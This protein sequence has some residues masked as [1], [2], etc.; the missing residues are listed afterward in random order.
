M[1]IIEIEI[2]L[3][4]AIGG[5]ER[6]GNRPAR[7]REEGGRHLRAVRHHHRNR[8]VPLDAE[9]A[10]RAAGLFDQAQQVAARH[11]LA[12][13]GANRRRRGIARAQQRRHGLE[14]VRRHYASVVS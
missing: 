1:E 6:R 2:E 13:R 5:I 8:M 11:G 12:V 14:A 7:D 3:V 4:G 9:C 10:E